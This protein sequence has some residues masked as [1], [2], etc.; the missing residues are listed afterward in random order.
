MPINTVGQLVRAA[1]KAHSQQEF[2]DMLGVKQSSISR[3]ESGKASP[4][5]SV[6]EQCMRLVHI[7]DTDAGP[8]A[9]QLAER[10]R[11][12]FAEPG[13]QDVRSAL[14]NLVNAFAAGQTQARMR[15]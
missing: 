6:I 7:D 15:R 1:R 12:V 14:S 3:Y 11:Q 5:I 4:P 9:D 2:A 13:L 8:T 10:V